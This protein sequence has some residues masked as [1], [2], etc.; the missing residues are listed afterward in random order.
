LRHVE[1]LVAGKSLKHSIEYWN[2]VKTE[3]QKI[4]DGVTLNE[5]KYVSPITT[6][7]IATWE[8]FF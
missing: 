3:V 7:I 5:N 8:F 2:H 4:L 6:G 1:E